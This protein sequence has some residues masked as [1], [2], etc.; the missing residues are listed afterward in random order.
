MSPGSSLTAWCPQTEVA[1]ITVWVSSLIAVTKFLMRGNIGGLRRIYSDWSFKTQ[2]ILIGK[3]S[4]H[5][6]STVK[7]QNDDRK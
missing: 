5:I 2:P 6:A 7:N 1:L 3:A 4:G